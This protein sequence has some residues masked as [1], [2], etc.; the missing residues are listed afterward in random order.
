MILV[1]KSH[2]K[3][4]LVRRRHRREDKIKVDLK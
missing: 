2:G 4:P 1:R 3:R